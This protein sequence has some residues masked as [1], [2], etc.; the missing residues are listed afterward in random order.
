[1]NDF[2]MMLM[3]VVFVLGYPVLIAAMFLG[4]KQDGDRADGVSLRQELAGLERRLMRLEVLAAQNVAEAPTA[5][6]VLAA[7]LSAPP[8]AEPA[9][10]QAAVPAPVAEPEP[11]PAPE[12]VA[13][14]APPATEPEPVPQAVAAPPSWRQRARPQRGA[15]VGAGDRGAGGGADGAPAAA[16]DAE[17]GRPGAILK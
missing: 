15:V 2:L 8:P 3:A 10:Q 13:L 11:E 12:S 9:L 6:M 1:M 16:A 4:R 17:R 14:P 5:G 7:E